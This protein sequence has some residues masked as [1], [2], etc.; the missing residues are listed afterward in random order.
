MKLKVIRR[1]LYETYTIGQ[2][3]I[4]FENGTG[5]QYFCDTLEDKVRDLNKD[6]DLQEPGETKVYGQTAIPYGTYTI[7][8]TKHLKWGI[9]VPYLTDVKEFTGVL[10]HMGSTPEQTLGCIL[11]GKN[12][13]KGQLTNSKNIFN[14]LMDVFKQYPQRTY[15]IEVV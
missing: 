1:Y 5:W 10:I 14:K 13:I 8:I 4:D 6:G 2:M 7:I 3:F 15:T 12:S 9:D 11:V